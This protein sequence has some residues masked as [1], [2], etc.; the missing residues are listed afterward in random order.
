M[1]LWFPVSL[2]STDSVSCWKATQGFS[3]ILG[4]STVNVPFT[5]TRL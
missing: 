3:E 2:L 5:Y 1:H 4:D